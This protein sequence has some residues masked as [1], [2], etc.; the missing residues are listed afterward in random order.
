MCGAEDLGFKPQTL[1]PLNHN[2]SGALA[3]CCEETFCVL[4][5]SLNSDIKTI[6]TAA[7]DLTLVSNRLWICS[8][9]PSHLALPG[10]S[11]AARRRP[12]VCGA[13]TSTSGKIWAGSGSTSRRATTPTTAWDPAPTSGMLKTNILRYSAAACSYRKLTSEPVV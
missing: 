7:L 12:A 9:S 5:P 6:V 2:C 3:R 13:C 11:H 4:N 8:V 10:F 1:K